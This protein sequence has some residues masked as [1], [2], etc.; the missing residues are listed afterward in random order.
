MTQ[1]LTMTTTHKFPSHANQDHEHGWGEHHTDQGTALL[2]YAVQREVA[3]K[4]ILTYS[5][6]EVNIEQCMKCHK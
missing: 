2:P 3:F 5:I 6:M 1:L 4:V